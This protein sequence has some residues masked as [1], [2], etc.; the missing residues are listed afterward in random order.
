MNTTFAAIEPP[1]A[2]IDAQVRDLMAY[3][4]IREQSLDK[5]LRTGP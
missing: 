4:G 1:R 2:E 3:Y 5:L